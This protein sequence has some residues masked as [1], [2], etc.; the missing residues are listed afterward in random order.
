MP[1]A[2]DAGWAG[3]AGVEHGV[4]GKSQVAGI[5]LRKEFFMP[6]GDGTGPPGAGRG[7]GRMGGP[8]AAGPGGQCMCPHCGYRVP[9]GQ[10]EPCN[11]KVC[12]KC[13]TRMTRG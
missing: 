5:D 6:R 7:G 12:P 11:Q 3:G 9:H 13:G 1:G 10:G 8:F 4:V 2:E